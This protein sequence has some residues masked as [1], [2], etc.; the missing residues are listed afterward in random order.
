MSKSA[1]DPRSRILITDSSKEIHDK[2]RVAFTDSIDPETLPE[3]PIPTLNDLSAGVANLY[4]IL[5]CCTNE[6]VATLIPK[7]CRLRYGH[8]KTAVAEAVDTKL[9]PIRTEYERLVKPENE[10][11]LREVV[12]TGRD[13]ATT[14][15]EENIGKIKQLLG[16]GVL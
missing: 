12:L 10:H 2:I 9:A 7:Y 11:W 13:R 3:Y 14:I 15:A 5:S 8:L 4:T 16:I 1:P 6:D